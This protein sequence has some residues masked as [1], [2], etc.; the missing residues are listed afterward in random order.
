MQFT[1]SYVPD[2]FKITNN[3]ANVAAGDTLQVDT[4]GNSNTNTVVVFDGSAETDGHFDFLNNLSHDV[5]IGG[6]LADNFD[7]SHRFGF[8]VTGGGG[9]DTFTANTLK[10][11]DFHA[12]Q[13]DIFVYNAVS[14]SRARATT[15]S[16]R[17]SWPTAR[18]TPAAR[19][20]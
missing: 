13:S 4:R 10:P 9:A 11:T 15:P 5:F 12:G 8:T 14:D 18:S 17:S 16:L 3:D 7:M 1:Q 19:V 6:A 20:L 2:S